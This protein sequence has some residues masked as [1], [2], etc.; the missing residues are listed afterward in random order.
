MKICYAC[1]FRFAPGDPY[2]IMGDGYDN[3]RIEIADIK[4]CPK[5]GAKLEEE[6]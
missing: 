5:C 3:R 1:G 4:D 6:R 2:L